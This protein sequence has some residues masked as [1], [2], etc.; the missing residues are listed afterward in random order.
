MGVLNSQALAGLMLLTA[1]FHR[2]SRPRRGHKEYL[3]L[4]YLTLK[5]FINSDWGGVPVF[6]MSLAVTSANLLGT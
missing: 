4:K 5:Y 3:L 2:F 6:R 1:V